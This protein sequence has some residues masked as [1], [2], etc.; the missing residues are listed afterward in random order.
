MKRLAAILVGGLVQGAAWAAAPLEVIVFPGGFNWPL[1][2]GQ[3]K[4]LFAANGVEVKITPT[5]NSVYQ[6]ENLVA[7]KF[8]IAFSAIDNVVAYDEGQGEVALPVAP[9]L[10]AFVGGQYGAVRLVTKP[11]IR[12]FAD[13]KGKSL[14]VDAATTGYAFVL[15][16]ILQ[17]NGL[18]ESDYTIERLG[19]TAAR[20]EALMQ[21]KTDGTILTSPLEIAPEAAGFR[22]LANAV[23]AIG[24]YQAVLG[25]ARRA[26]AKEHEAEL[27]GFI[28]G[29]VAALA[30]L[31]DPA[32]R[33]EAAAIYR[34]NLP[35]ASEAAALKAWDVMLAGPEGFQKK[36]EINLA[37]V[38][39]VLELRSE[40]GRPQKNLTD[41]SKYIDESY[42]RK[43]LR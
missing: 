33:D 8:D 7:G 11:E 1:W 17:K 31:A 29:Y 30:W 35:R 4:G 42:Y 10:F 15:R 3:E 22:R 28:R 38:R 41:P 43:A 19:G 18:A 5:P 21:G 26:W 32:H 37:G 24:P 25:V 16:K 2:V 23:D 36:G 40:Y 27:V 6:M 39:T 34:K 20:A 9:D 12:T 14:A 13:L